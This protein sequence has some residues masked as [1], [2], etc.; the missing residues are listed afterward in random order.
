MVESAPEPHPPVPPSGV[1]LSTEQLI[2][3]LY[4]ELRRLARARLA[5]EPVGQTLQPTALVHEAYLRLLNTPDARW[6]T[7]GH[8]FAAAAQAMRRI[9]IERA[10]RK[11]RLRHGGEAV[12]IEMEDA[13]SV[14]A[15]PHEDLLALEEAL[16]AL[17]MH[18][19][20]LYDLVHLRYF[21][22]LSIEESAELL[23]LS[24]TTVKDDWLYARTWLHR[25]MTRESPRPL[26]SQENIRHDLDG[27]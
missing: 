17:R 26:P 8:F 4:D 23:G 6:D 15:E 13:F 20:R 5:R 18:D 11:K 27:P 19:A 3:F 12:R 24:Q 25:V 9:L 22:G 2:L 21:A 16:E 14:L 1:P 10:R 7:R